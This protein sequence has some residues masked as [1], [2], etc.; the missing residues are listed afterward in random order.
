MSEDSLRDKA[1]APGPDSPRPPRAKRR[2]RR[3]LLFGIPAAGILLFVVAVEFTSTSRFCSS[4]HYMKPFFE[5]WKTSTHKDVEC[6]ACHYP[7]G[8]RSFFRTKIEGLVMVGRYWTRL[9][10]KSKPWAEIQDASCLRPGCHDRRLLEG[11]VQFGKVAFDH[12]AHFEDLKRG[13]TLRCTSCHSQIVQGEHI[14]VTAESCFLC[15]F[16]DKTP[17]VRAGECAV[18]HRKDELLAL[19]DRFDHTP[20]FGNGYRCDKCHSRIVTGDGEVPRENC[21]KCHF[22]QDRLDQ[23]GDTDLMHR[24]HITVSKIECEQCHRGI[25]HKIV[26]DIETIADCQA[27]HQGTHG[28][29]KILYTGQ[30]GKGVPHA[31]PNV[32]WEKGLSCQGCHMFHEASAKVDNSDTL[33]ASGEACESCHG[34]GFDRI[35]K[36]WERS[37]E[38]RLAEVKTI[39]ARAASEISAAPGPKKTSAAALLEEARF[40][41]DVV[42]KGKSVHNMTYSQEL[43]TS[44]LEKIREAM[45]A[46]GSSYKPEAMTLLTRETPNACLNCHAGIEEI[47][48]S[49]FGLGFSHR[50]HAVVQKLECATCHSNARRHGELTATRS[51]CATCHHQK[52]QKTCGQCHAL[53]KTLFEGG[54]LGEDTVPKDMMAEAGT[55]CSDCHL[56]EAKK[57]VRPDGGACVACHDENYRKTFTEWRDGVRGRVEGIR[58]GLHA[59]YKRTLTD[60]EKAVVGRIEKALE[61]VGLDGSSGVH[62]YMFVDEYLTKLEA[63]IKSLSGGKDGLE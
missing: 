36:N 25:E 53:Q 6:K 26:K 7:P 11:Q 40:N 47:E 59:L 29:Q 37:T 57:V 23:F 39:A 33:T 16:K 42:E 48:A 56:D 3:L 52:P 9:Y 8:M 28:A 50:R 10:V 13:K 22:E 18:C 17:D 55:S 12:K 24:M 58:A 14:T 15:H 5:S 30:G 1:A 41:I 44:S 60:A 63:Q 49:A 20:V 27:C 43:L 31:T 61:M 62:N 54:T 34:R 32:M 2:R 19:K 38:K 4:C 45:A 35:L 51:S 21:F 46:A